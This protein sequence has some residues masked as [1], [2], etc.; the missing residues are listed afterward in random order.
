MSRRKPPAPASVEAAETPGAAPEE[1]AILARLESGPGWG[2]ALAA[3]GLA[4]VAGLG[5]LVFHRFRGRK[6]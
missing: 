3:G 5:V 6:T 1:P 2:L 4:V